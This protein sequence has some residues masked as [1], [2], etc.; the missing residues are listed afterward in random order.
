MVEEKSKR[1]GKKL[2]CYALSDCAPM[3]ARAMPLWL[4]WVKSEWPETSD[5][6]IRT[7]M[8]RRAAMKRRYG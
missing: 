1:N 7:F 6:E 2:N 4:Q 3:M 5:N 8:L